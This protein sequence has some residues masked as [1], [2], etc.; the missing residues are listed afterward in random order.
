MHRKPCV[1]TLLCHFMISAHSGDIIF[2]HW[3]V[4]WLHQLR[5][6]LWGV[7]LLPQGSRQARPPWK[8]GT[9][10]A[11][12]SKAGEEQEGKRVEERHLME[13]EEC[14]RHEPRC[15][16]HN[17]GWSLLHQREGCWQRDKLG[18]LQSWVS[19][20]QNGRC[21]AAD[22]QN[23]DRWLPDSNLKPCQLCL[24]P[25]PVPVLSWFHPS[26]NR[27]SWKGPWAEYCSLFKTSF[28]KHSQIQA[29]L[30]SKATSFK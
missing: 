13:G 25:S 20:G 17:P 10:V 4:I 22:R 15:G 23:R 27:G 30:N 3:S 12:T 7:T 2:F 16:Y 8:P 9:A 14:G 11:A 6:Q 24:W 19:T 5:L 28:W 21:W 26:S 1:Q 29:G 18:C